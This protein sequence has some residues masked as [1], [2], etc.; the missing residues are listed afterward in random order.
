M[1]IRRIF[2]RASTGAAIK[3]IIED[4]EG[5]HANSPSSHFS[6]FTRIRKMY[7]DE[8]CFEAA[9]N[10]VPNPATQVRRDAD[11]RTTRI[12]NK[13][14]AAVCDLFNGVYFWILTLLLQYF[15][16]SGESDAQRAEIKSAAARTMSVA[17]RPIA[18]VLTEMPFGDPQD[19]RRGGPSFELAGPV[20]FPRMLPRDGRCCSSVWIRL[21]RSAPDLPA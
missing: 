8:G 13:E 19:P 7:V 15:S 9:R 4:G 10:V 2:D 21:R 17:I 3:D 14:T 11:A 1:D 6:R 18:E 12:E 5:A 20:Y 16:R